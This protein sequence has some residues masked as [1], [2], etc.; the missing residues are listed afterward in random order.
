MYIKPNVQTYSLA[1]IKELIEL[2]NCSWGE[3]GYYPR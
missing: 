1:A 3:C 2:R